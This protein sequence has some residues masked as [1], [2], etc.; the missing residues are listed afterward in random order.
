MKNT[1][2]RA[3]S[4]GE[5]LLRRG[6]LLSILQFLFI[7][8]VHSQFKIVK[9]NLTNR[10]SELRSLFESEKDTVYI[11]QIEG[12]WNVQPLQFKGLRDK[13]IYFEEGNIIRAIPGA[14]PNTTDVLLGFTDCRNIEIYGAGLRLEMSKEEYLDGE[15][16]HAL[17]IRGCQNMRLT[18]M[19]IRSSG[20]DGIYIAGSR[21]YN[22]SADINIEHIISSN[23]KRQ[24]ISIISGRD[25]EVRNST[26]EKTKGTLP[27]AGVDLEPNK[28]TD[29]IKNIL[30]EN[31]V[32]RDNDHAGIL[33][34]LQHL[35][36]QS[37]P[38]SVSFKNCLLSNN[39]NPENDYIASEIV[40]NARSEN[41]VKGQV[42]FEDCMVDGSNW[43]LVYSRKSAEAFHVTFRNILVRD[44][45]REGNYP[46]IYLEVADYRNGRH[47]LG[48]FHFDQVTIES[49]STQPFLKI[50]G[51]R[52]GTL[53]GVEDLKGKF[54]LKGKIG[55]D[56]EYI[57]YN[58]LHNK[59]VD[60][61]VIVE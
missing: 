9:Q 16:R 14:Y 1:T 46:P 31:C 43:G 15:W 49:E 25:I 56:P 52:L 20:G 54:I 58:S 4:W 23:H 35:S 22:E 12:D 11:P 28:S 19:V 18:N 5:L 42:L 59:N 41:P 40:L 36:S 57:N 61:D 17:S 8:T 37:E 32:F 48:G 10:T 30:F 39:H 55:S 3:Y 38:V 13:V 33:V 27:G 51:S 34:S 47:S 7:L 60:L 45:G 24:G 53:K 21:N 50:R 29:V 44:I 6:A 26:F 2:I